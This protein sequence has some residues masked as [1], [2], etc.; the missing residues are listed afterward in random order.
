MAREA[1]IG[2][3]RQQPSARTGSHTE[4]HTLWVGRGLRVRVREGV[5]L[6]AEPEGAPPPDGRHGPERRLGGRVHLR[7]DGQRRQLRGVGDMCVG[8]VKGQRLP[9]QPPRVLVQQPGLARGEAQRQQLATVCRNDLGASHQGVSPAKQLQDLQQVCCGE[10]GQHGG[11][12]D[13][14][15]EEHTARDPLQLRPQAAALLSSDFGRRSSE[16]GVGTQAA[17]WQPR[18]SPHALRMHRCA[19]RARGTPSS[20]VEPFDVH[21]AVQARGQQPA[22]HQIDARDVHLVCHEQP[23]APVRRPLCT[24]KTPTLAGDADASPRP[25]GRREGRSGGADGARTTT[26]LVGASRPG[27]DAMVVGRDRELARAIG[28]PVRC[29]RQTPGRDWQAAVVRDVLQRRR[30]G[31][32]CVCSHHCDMPS[33]TDGNHDGPLDQPPTTYSID[34]CRELCEA[35]HLF[36]NSGASS[37]FR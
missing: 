6:Q 8:A 20:G 37:S 32:V 7:G 27:F 9:A 15:G 36:A 4:N 34:L 18:S 5:E 14:L 29:Q 19:D 24:Q 16:G 2:R 3:Q 11:S 13:L 22:V 23:A 35:L 21:G 1:P 33:G 30:D 10:Q 31:A 25:R 17:Q 28:A 26:E 12:N